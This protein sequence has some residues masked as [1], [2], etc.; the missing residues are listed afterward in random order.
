MPLVAAISSCLC[1]Y[2][3]YLLPCSI[4]TSYRCCHRSCIRLP[5]L[6]PTATRL[7]APSSTTVTSIATATIAALFFLCQPRRCWL[8]A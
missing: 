3:L 6:P 1:R 4:A 7:V 8:P 2:L 5:H